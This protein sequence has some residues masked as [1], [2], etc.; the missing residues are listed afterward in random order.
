MKATKEKVWTLSCCKGKRRVSGSKREAIEAAKLMDACLQ[1]AWG[2]DIRDAEEN[3]VC[4][5]DD[6]RIDGND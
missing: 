5:V 4:N 3:F 6:G 1:P 2:V